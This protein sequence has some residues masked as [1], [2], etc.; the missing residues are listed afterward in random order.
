MNDDPC[1]L[2]INNTNYYTPCNS[3]EYIVYD[4]QNNILINTS[5]SSITL[6]YSYPVLNDNS[7][8]Y[9][10]IQASG[11]QVF[12]YRQSYQSSNQQLQVN[13]FKIINQ[14][15]PTNVLLMIVMIGVTVIHLFKR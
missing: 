2:Q 9:P 11:N 12:Y 10:R 8:G 3:M 7:S 4:D 5:S 14:H 13:Q 1:V 6:Y 15:T